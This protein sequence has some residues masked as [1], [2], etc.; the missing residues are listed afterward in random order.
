MKIV[1]LRDIASRCIGGT[2]VIGKAGEPERI[3]DVY[4]NAGARHD[5]KVVFIVKGRRERA[6][7]FF[8]LCIRLADGTYAGEDDAF[9][10]VPLDRA[11]TA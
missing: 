4:V 6:F 5:P 8:T 7:D 3:E 10:L 2:I 11:N 1:A 9:H